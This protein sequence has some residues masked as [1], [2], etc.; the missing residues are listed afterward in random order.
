M[1][2]MKIDIKET[3]A[4]TVAAVECTGSFD[5][6]SQ[7][8]MDLFRWVLL[9]GG[10]VTSYPMAL[11][12]SPP[13]QVPAEGVRFE[14]CIPVGGRLEPGNG[15]EIRRIPAATVAYIR[16][17]GGY[18]KV[19][20]S[21]DRILIWAS[22]NGYEVAGPSRELYLTNPMQ[23]PEGELVTEIQVPVKT[24]ESESP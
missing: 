21:Y 16:H 10:K 12:P 11:F 6:I 14:V 24:V 1:D 5:E 13:E 4:L 22:N 18:G 8:F 19:G 20:M 23:T 9:S 2:T 3:P 15:V 7:V 17:E